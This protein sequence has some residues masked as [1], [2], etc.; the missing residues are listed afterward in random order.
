MSRAVAGIAL[1]AT[2][3]GFGF[4]VV[5]TPTPQ[6]GADTA[7]GPPPGVTSVVANGTPT[8]E[9][10]ANAATIVNVGAQMGAGQAGQVIAIATSLV[11]S[12]LL[13]LNHGDRDSLGL[14]QQRPSAGWGT[15]AQIMDPIYAATKFYEHLLNLP[16]WQ[17]MDPG[18]AAQAVQRS[19][20]PSRYAERM[21]EAKAILASLGQPV[22]VVTGNTAAGIDPCVD[23]G[24]ATPNLGVGQGSFHDGPN[25]GIP[26]ANPR[27]TTDA[28]AW[29]EA[30]AA[31]GRGGW[32]RRCL[33]FT[34]I[35]YGWSYSGVSYAIDH[36]TTVPPELRHP[37]DRNPMP[38]ALLYWDTG[39]RAGHIAVYL[40]NGMLA[41]NDIVT[42]GQISV[43]PADDIEKKWGAR[44][45]GWT[46]PYF[47]L[48]G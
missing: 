42:N 48:G 12:G 10:R 33:A 34:A 39:S 36:Y 7:C 17:A 38:G 18:M 43:V 31:S 46:P 5:F 45:V 20:F 27:S 28:I 40:G 9:K 25:V 29:A 11:E 22:A 1:L 41:S 30:E 37:A 44:Y 13:N 47:P 4:V 24:P 15:P 21:T 19:A 8:D 16:G 2:V 23:T 3:V 35:T 32:Y 14:F 26:R 6:A